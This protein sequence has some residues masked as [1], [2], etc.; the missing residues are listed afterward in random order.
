MEF[1]TGSVMLILSLVLGVACAAGLL[2]VVMRLMRPRAMMTLLLIAAAPAVWATTPDTVDPSMERFLTRQDE[3]H[4]YRAARRLEAENGSRRGWLEATTEYSSDHGFRYQITSEGGSDQIRTR[5]LKAV[6]DGEREMIAI[7]EAARSALAPAN[8]TFQPNGID[9]DGL[10]N[11]LLS[12]RR[13][14]RALLSGVMFLRPAEG[15]LVRLQGRLAKNP[16]FWVRNV[17]IVRKYSRIQNVVVPVALEST[18]HVRFL[19]AASFRMTYDY[20]E[21]D[22]RPVRH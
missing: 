3:Q 14:E 7:G 4:P 18:A 1:V 13:K 19:G 10:A 5:V 9:A 15:E 12:P 22:G 11:I 6:L 20:Q 16:S 17:D 21:I 8:Y 2:V